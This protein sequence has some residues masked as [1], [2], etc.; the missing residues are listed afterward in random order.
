MVN[1][2]QKAA[3][4]AKKAGFLSGGLLLCAAG[5]A[6]LTVAVWFA[7]LPHYGV[8]MT[9]TLVGCIYLGAGCIFIAVGLRRTEPVEK[10]APTHDPA[11]S[12]DPSVLQAFMYGLQAGT[13]ARQARD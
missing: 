11:T 2:K 9:A 6:F 12:D 3:K 13:K 1:I 7:L 10:S 8:P 5:I 4:T